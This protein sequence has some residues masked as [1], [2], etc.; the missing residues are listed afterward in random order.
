MAVEEGEA[1]EL[2]DRSEA[3]VEEEKDTNDLEGVEGVEVVG[4]AAFETEV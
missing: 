2:V 4:G 3:N 1:E